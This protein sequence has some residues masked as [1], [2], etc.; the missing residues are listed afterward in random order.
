LVVG[1]LDVLKTFGLVLTDSYSLG[2]PQ[3][4]VT[5]VSV[6]GGD[7]SIDLTEFSGG[8]RYGDR[9]QTFKLAAPHMTQRQAENAHSRL[10]AYL[11]YQ[12]FDYTLG[13]D[14]GYTYNG[15][16]VVGE[17]TRENGLSTITVT[18]TARPWKSAGLLTL[19]IN[20]AGGVTFD[21]VNGDREV[22]PTIEVER[23]SIVAYGG[24]SWTLEP[25]AHKVNDL[26]LKPGLS[27]MT[28][29]TY[30]DY[31][32]QVLSAVA[33]KTLQQLQDTYG[34]LAGVA[35][36]DTP[37]N[38]PLT[39]ESYFDS[40]LG[41]IADRHLFELSHPATKGDEYSAYVQFERQYL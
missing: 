4:K 36:G 39:L 28:I 31:S 35:A 3:P 26:W 12:R 27:Q 32:T 22:C 14:P 15:R 1:G 11:D 41:S 29:D 2:V 8:V 10:T 6:P 20:A 24:T 7:G 25:G 34:T 19:V 17:M 18:V 30:P 16:F 37:V 21:I 5:T 40:T 23:E 33:T 13:L 38:V 9:T